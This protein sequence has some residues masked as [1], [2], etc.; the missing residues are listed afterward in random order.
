MVRAYAGARAARRQRRGDALVRTKP[1]GGRRGVVDRAAHDRMAEGEAAAVARRAHE[2]DGHEPVEWRRDRAGV[3]LGG[4]RRE[5]GVERVAGDRCALDQRPRRARQHLQLDADRRGHARRHPGPGARQL[6]QE[7]RVAV[8]LAGDPLAIGDVAQQRERL[9][10][11][12]RFQVQVLGAG[13]ERAHRDAAFRRAQREHEQVRR[14]RRAAQQ[15]LDELDRR[16]VRPV[17]VV[18]RQ[19]DRALAGEQ[20]DQPA[21]RPVVAEALRGGLGRGGRR[22][23]VR[24]GRQHRAEPGIQRLDAARVQGRNMVVERGD[25]ERERHLAL[26][27]GRAP[28][29]RE[30]P[31]RAGALRGGFQQRGL[32]DPRLTADQ[33]DARLAAAHVLHRPLHRVEL[34]IASYEVHHHDR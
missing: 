22:H 1:P 29:E 14:A 5:L 8:G 32:A 15:V 31:G 19:S 33:H 18:Q 28:G 7:Q 11:A 20:L 9:V 23:A 4:E 13:V 12:E 3:Q 16:V 25:G 24:R 17:Q 27:L 34:A 26:V 6:V 10:M 2:V 30:Q 21:Q